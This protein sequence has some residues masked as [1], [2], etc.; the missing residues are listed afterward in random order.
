MQ[1]ELLYKLN[2]GDELAYKTIVDE[3]YPVLVAFA[4]KYLSD[5]DVSKD[6]AQNVFV[7]FYEKRH[8]IQITSSLKSYLFKM[9]YHECLNY[10]KS[11]RTVLGH[12]S[13]YAKEMEAREDFQ[14]TIEQ[15]EEEYRIFKALENLPP[16]C[17]L[18][19][20][21]SRLNGKKNQEIA[22]EMNISVRTVET[23]ISKALKILKSSL[24]FLF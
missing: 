3:Y 16:K 12:Y 23:Q 19:I 2:N 8:S 9:V 1:K 17:R 7:K 10:L 24:S 18:I 5:L 22:E 6:I 20:E 15:T 13:E 4:N 14:D 21:Q 11:K